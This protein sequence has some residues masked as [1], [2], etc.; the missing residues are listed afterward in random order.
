MR[1]LC[2]IL[3]TI[4]ITSCA[5]FNNTIQS[6]YI[7]RDPIGYDTTKIVNNHPTPIYDSIYVVSPTWKQAWKKS[8]KTV[9]IIGLTTTTGALIG[10]PF[11]YNPTTLTPIAIG[12]LALTGSSL[13][14][15][16]WNNDKEIRKSE[17]DSL[18]KSDGNL[19]SFWVKQK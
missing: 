11:V 1:T 13:E 18:M 9:P 4:L 8:N 17:Y 10:A 12:G 16:R 7:S 5:T 3:T 6:R 2:L 15:Y 19:K 14:W